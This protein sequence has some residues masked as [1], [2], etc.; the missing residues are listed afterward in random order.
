MITVKAIEIFGPQ[1][2]RF[3]SKS[4]YIRYNYFD[5]KIDIWNVSY[6]GRGQSGSFSD[7]IKIK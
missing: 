3:F 1:Y 2:I 7:E 5:R 6:S 4:F